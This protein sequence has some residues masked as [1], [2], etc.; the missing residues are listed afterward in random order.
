MSTVWSLAS[1]PGCRVFPHETRRPGCQG[2]MRRWRVKGAREGAPGAWH[3][4]NLHTV[5][6]AALETEACTTVT[7]EIV[8]FGRANEQNCSSGENESE[9]SSISMTVL[10]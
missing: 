2:G 4:R 7:F 8:S 3:P 5:G 9:E 1:R 10:S 6:S